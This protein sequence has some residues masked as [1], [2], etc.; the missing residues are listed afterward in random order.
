LDVLAS[1]YPWPEQGADW[2]V[3]REQLIEKFTSKIEILSQE[4]INQ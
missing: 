4:L 3:S 1:Q 2:G